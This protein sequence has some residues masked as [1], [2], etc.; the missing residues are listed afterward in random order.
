MNIIN[1]SVCTSLKSLSRAGN[2]TSQISQLDDMFLR[3]QAWLDC[4]G[5]TWQ[6]TIKN[7]QV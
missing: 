4:L 5:P 7:D 2:I 6:H 3:S 1:I